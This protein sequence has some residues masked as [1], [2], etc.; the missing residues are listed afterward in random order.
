MYSTAAILRDQNT[1]RDVSLGIEHS[2]RSIKL[3]FLFAFHKCSM[4]ETRGDSNG[5]RFKNASVSRNNILGTVTI[6]FPTT[7]S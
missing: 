7:A 5:A 2:I 1:D 6:T 4:K 3:L